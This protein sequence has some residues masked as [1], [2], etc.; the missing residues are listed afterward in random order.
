MRDRCCFI[1][2][3]AVEQLED[4]FQMVMDI[5]SFESETNF[6]LSLFHEIPLVTLISD[7][8][9]CDSMFRFSTQPLVQALI[10][11]P[12]FVTKLPEFMLTLK[13]L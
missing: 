2:T 6:P 12:L 8:R 13:F 11:A 7:H 3:G 1:K 10:H 5:Y 4:I 9:C